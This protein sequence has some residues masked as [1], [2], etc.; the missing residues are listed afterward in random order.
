MEIWIR[1]LLAWAVFTIATKWVRP[2][3][4]S[5]DAAWKGAL[6]VGAAWLIVSLLHAIFSST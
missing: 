6:F 5:V 1:L 3:A 2:E 4:G